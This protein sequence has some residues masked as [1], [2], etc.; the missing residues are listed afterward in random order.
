M[1]AEPDYLHG[2][3]FPGESEEYRQARDALLR[4]EKDVRDR[5]EAVAE[6][7]R[8]LPLGGVVPSDYEFQEWDSS[9]GT[10]RAVR[11]SELFADGKDTL[12]LY[13][14]MFIEGPDGNPIGSPC[15]NCTSIIDAV[16]GQAVHL[17]QRINLAVLAKA[18]IEQFRA[19]AHSRR[20]ADIRLLSSAENAFNVDY[21]AEDEE[22]RQWPIA[23][24]FVRHDG[25]IHH[26]W[27]SE[28]FWGSHREGE[29]SRHVDFMWPY[30]NILDCTPEG[31]PKENT[32]RLEYPS[33]G[34]AP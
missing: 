31:R 9:T 7:R 19:H 23:H 10:R 2:M 32:P 25:Q 15:P 12:F 21:G 33:P 27:S 3:R 30:W 24:V 29:E 4:A 17:T 1:T 22:G 34:A 18:P 20:W 16:A 5:T 13:S 11:L 8:Q 14:F 28:L 6:Q 26:W